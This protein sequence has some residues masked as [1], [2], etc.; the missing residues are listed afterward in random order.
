M[1][2]I[3]RIISGGQT[4]VDQGALEAALE[5]KFPCGGWCPK[6]RRSET[7]VIPAHFP[8]RE[9]SSG[10]YP[11]RT[12]LNVRDSDGTLILTRGGSSRGTDLTVN[13]ARSMNR[14]LEILDLSQVKSTDP[15]ERLIH[16]V[17]KHQIRTL[18]FAGP[19]ESE[20][21]GIGLEAKELVTRLIQ[22]LKP[23]PEVGQEI[24]WPPPHPTTPTFRSLEK[25]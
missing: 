5:S 2:W 3:A 13:L 17:E 4:G 22:A 10:D 1:A 19:R 7:G 12:R 6:G 20:A 21:P 25:E 9:T 23:A 11:M 16:W 8:L 14:P 24:P 18:N 15:M